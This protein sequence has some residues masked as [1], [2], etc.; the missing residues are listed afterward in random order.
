MSK[1]AKP[2]KDKNKKSFLESFLVKLPWVIAI[3][4]FCM[5]LSL[6]AMER[7]PGPLKEGFESYFS[8]ISGQKASILS[9]E[10]IAFF[11]ELYIQMKDM[12]FSDKDNVAITNMTIERGKIHIPFLSMFIGGRNIY[13]LEIHNLHASPDVITPHSIDIKMLDIV[14]I[15]DNKDKGVLS[16]SGEYADKPLSVNVGLTRKKTLLGNIVYKIPQNT[17][18]DLGIGAVSFKTDF[19]NEGGNIWFRN[20]VLSYKNIDKT[21][22]DSVFVKDRTVNKENIMA[23]LLAHNYK[24]VDEICNDYIRE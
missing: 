6:K 2:I 8:D 23:C 18:I 16:I 22:E 19:I 3:T 4:I 14:D 15:A 1:K 13:D 10:K 5:I 12:V 7:F 24:A 20:G 17:S 21:V 11:P 9:L